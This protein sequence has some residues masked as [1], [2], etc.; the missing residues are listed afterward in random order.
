VFNGLE[1][2]GVGDAKGSSV[3]DHVCPTCGSTLYWVIDGEHPIMA[4]TVGNLVD[5]GFPAPD[6]ELH[7]ERRHHWV[8]IV[9][10]AALIDPA[11]S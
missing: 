9:P 11:G 5:P 8:P 2:D 10:G 7:T 3:S 6:M 1:I 4:M